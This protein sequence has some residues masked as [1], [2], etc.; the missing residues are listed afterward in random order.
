MVGYERFYKQDYSTFTEIILSRSKLRNSTS[1][2]VC[3]LKIHFS[4]ISKF[5]SI[6]YNEKLH[7]PSMLRFKSSGIPSIIFHWN[8]GVFF[9]YLKYKTFTFYYCQF[10]LFLRKKFDIISFL[11]SV[12][13]SNRWTFLTSGTTGTLSNDWMEENQRKKN[14]R[15]GNFRA[16]CRQSES[17]E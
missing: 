2:S 11:F 1:M 7:I 6:K 3:T 16:N 17:S 4:N 13:F 12:I 8:E 9:V 15:G 10:D 5:I 14:G